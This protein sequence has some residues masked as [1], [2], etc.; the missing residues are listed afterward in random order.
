MNKKSIKKVAVI[1]ML[2][3]LSMT[4][5]TGCVKPYDKPTFVTIEANETAFLIPLVG[6][7]SDQAVFESESLLNDT[8]VATKEVQIPHRWVQTGRMYWIGQYRDN[9]TVIKVN[10]SP[11]T[12]EWTS[13]KSTGTNSSDQGV[14]AKTK[15]GIKIILN[16]N[17]TAQIDEALAT[18]YLY[19]YNKNELSQ[20]MDTEIKTMVHS[21]LIEETSKYNLSELNTEKIMSVV[22]PEIQEYFKGRGI[23]V[24]A[25]GFSSDPIY[26]ED[27][28]QAMNE[29]VKAIQTQ[30][31]QTIANKT[32]IDKAKAEVEQANL[33]KSTLETQMKLK[34]LEIKQIEAE[35]KKIQAEKWDGHK[36]Q[37][38][39]VSSV[40]PIIDMK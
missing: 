5:M 8:K 12:R 4:S 33:Q 10:R 3:A 29:K 19:N 40:S 15:D 14:V 28:Q 16:V 22:K 38:E 6:D 26:P 30:E 11:V 2:G 13:D 32:A 21:R 27:I 9:A 37:I 31:A 24:T 39:G 20:I 34:E 7:T 36:A 18:K 35:A 25:L 17:S 23:T 1:G